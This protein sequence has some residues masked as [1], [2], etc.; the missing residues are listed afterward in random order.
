MNKITNFN[1]F[2]TTQNVLSTKVANKIPFKGDKTSISNS[3]PF[4][5]DILDINKVQKTPV[6]IDEKVSLKSIISFLGEK[7]KS[8]N[9]KAQLL[10]VF[11]EK[12][13]DIILKAA[14]K[15]NIDCVLTLAQAKMNGTKNRFSYYDIVQLLQVID[16]NTKPALPILLKAFLSCQNTPLNANILKAALKEINSNTLDML[17]IMINPETGQSDRRFQMGYD[18]SSFLNEITIDNKATIKALW[19]AKNADDTPKIS[20]YNVISFAKNTKSQDIPLLLD[21][22]NQNDQYNRPL[23]DDC[24]ISSILNST[25]ND[26]KQLLTQLSSLPNLNGHRITEVISNF[27]SSCIDYLKQ[28]I[29]DSYRLDLLFA[30]HKFSEEAPIF[31]IIESSNYD[32]FTN[33]EKEQ[34]AGLISKKEYKNILSNVRNLNVPLLPAMDNRDDFINTLLAGLKQNINLERLPQERVNHFKYHLGRLYDN[35]KNINPAKEIDFN[36][37]YD[38][39]NVLINLPEYLTELKNDL[40]TLIYVLPETRSIFADSNRAKSAITSLN[41]LFNDETFNSLTDKEK[42]FAKLATILSYLPAGENSTAKEVALDA[43]ISISRLDYSQR[44]QRRLFDLVKNQN[45]LKSFIST[46]QSLKG[47]VSE[48]FVRPGDFEILT[49]IVKAK[50]LTGRASD[51]IAIYNKAVSELKPVVKEI[52]NTSIN[53]PQ[54]QIPKASQLHLPYEEIGHDGRT[55]NKIV[56]MNE[57]NDFEG[58]GFSQGTNR[59]NI[60]FL[61]HVINENIDRM[62]AEEMR[63]PTT[64]FDCRDVVNYINYI[65]TV[66]ES[67]FSASLLSMNNNNVF[68]HQRWGFVFDVDPAN[69]A[70]ASQDDVWSGFDKNENVFTNNLFSVKRNCYSDNVKNELAKNIP[71]ER[72]TAEYSNLY[73]KI[74]LQEIEQPVANAVKNAIDNG[75]MNAK[76]HNE[77]L[78]RS[79][80]VKAIFCKDDDPGALPYTLRHYAETHDLPIIMFKK[81]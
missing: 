11:P 76:E 16:N 51:N 81:W 49:S 8:D 80:K 65:D 54:T 63:A 6:N 46:N 75:L 29:N 19:L 37:I 67:N 36:N 58:I 56:R 45:R 7:V 41:A 28:N 22:L 10:E 55:N 31:K 32:S 48:C 1:T 72:V 34:L 61:T 9:V 42:E 78:V 40:N 47:V 50:I 38:S 35:L 52:V 57:I 23:F 74:S 2:H 62:L 66:G 12:E 20:K 5:I 26:K 60:Y 77:L 59:D 27:N 25:K 70:I 79:P 30:L 71:S 17:D 4:A 21:L 15:E 24:D 73:N 68:I 3:N 18:I 33:K 13:V 44:E 39:E 64:A 14:N 53:L 43:R 69:I